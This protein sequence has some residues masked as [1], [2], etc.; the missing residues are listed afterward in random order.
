MADSAR[1]RAEAELKRDPARSHALISR[2]AQCTQQDAARWRRVLE[3]AGEIP[4]V[5]PPQRR[6]GPAFATTDRPGQGFY[7]LDEIERP[8]CT[9]EW[10]DG[11]WQ[12][13]RSCT[14]RLAAR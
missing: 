8:C 12:H 3:R 7:Q 13:D 9:M 14:L 4:A 1:D 2:A 5:S 10:Q 11:G 6:H